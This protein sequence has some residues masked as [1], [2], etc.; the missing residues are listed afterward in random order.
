MHEVRRFMLVVL[1]DP[2]WQLWKALTRI[3]NHSYPLTEVN[4]K[5]MTGYGTWP[6][7]TDPHQRDPHRRLGGV[8]SRRTRHPAAVPGAGHADGVLR[9]RRRPAVPGRAGKSRVP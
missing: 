3:V 2:S 1:W 9:Q 8:L 4:Y 6:S 7:R 5:D